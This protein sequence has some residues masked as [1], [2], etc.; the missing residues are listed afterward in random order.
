MVSNVFVVKRKAMLG[1]IILYERKLLR[2]KI[3]IPNQK[4][5]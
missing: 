4:L 3:K 1:M 5:E 2:K